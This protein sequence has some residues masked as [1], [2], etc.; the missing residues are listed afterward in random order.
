M[1]S[2]FKFLDSYT[3]DD[4]E[5]FFGR[6]REIEELYHRVFESK[7]MLVYGVSGT[8]KSSLIYCG[9]ANKFQETDWLPLNIRRGSNIIESFAS[10]IKSSS[11][12]PQTGEISTPGQFKKAVRSLYLDHYKPVFF[13][14][15]QF[16][17]LFIFGNKDEKRSF[18][19][20]IKSLVDSDIQCR[21]IFVM[22]E[23]YMANITEFEKFIPTIFSNRVRIEKMSHLNAIAAIKGPC[24][25]AGISLE[26]G[27]AE[28]LLEK[29]SPGSTDVE[30][31]Y[32]Q[33]FLDR[34]LRLTS[35]NSPLSSGTETL[36]RVSMGV[37]GEVS[38]TTR[39]ILQG[40]IGGG[41]FFTTSLLTHAGNVS[42]ILGNFL[43]DQIALME[44]PDDAM[45]VL[46]A[47]IS[48][49]GTKRPASESE[50]I[51]NVRSLGKD[52]PAERV[53]EQIQL[54]VNL[55]LLRDKD[56]KGRYELRHDALASKIFEKFTLSEKELLEVRKYIENAFYSYETRGI[57]LNKQDL[58]YLA[59]Y[60][61]KL[62]LPQN[63][64]DYVNQSRFK[65][66]SQRKALIRMTRIS[67][68]IFVL[69]IAAI[70]RS[71]LGT[72]KNSVLNNQ[73][74]SALFQSKVNPGKGLFTALNIWGK[75]SSSPVLQ[76]I[77]LKDFQKIISSKPDS[78]NPFFPISKDLEPVKL[79]SPVIKAEISKKGTFI[80][81]CMENNKAFILN[82]VTNR[83][84]I[85]KTDG[86]LIHIEI[87]EKDSLIALVYNNNK[88]VVCDFNGN[89]RYTFE[90]TCNKIM[91]ERLVRFFPSGDYQLVTTKNN[92]ALI[93]DK[94]GKIVFELK[95]HSGKVNS[96]DVSP[97][98]RFVATASADKRVFLW[99]YNHISKQL[100][101]YDSLIGHY[102]T[103]WSCQFNRT[104]KYVITAS[105][106]STI[107]IWNLKGKE[108]NPEFRFAREF[109]GDPRSKYNKKE[110]DPDAANPSFSAYY[111]KFCNASFSSDEKEIVA[112]GYSFNSDSSDKKVPFYNKVLYF[113]YY[114]SFFKWHNYSFIDL[115]INHIGT[116][117]PE[118]F[119]QLV[120]SDIGNM[121][122][123]ANEKSGKIY[124]VDA[125]GLIFL[126]LNG[127]NP[128]FSDNGNEILW[129]NKNEIN[130][131]P[132]T[133]EKINR[134]LKRNNISS[135]LK[136]IEDIFVEL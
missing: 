100:S 57:M 42:D 32:L 126:T 9:L 25:I 119:N 85:L 30:L 68:L 48:G 8:G 21:F 3:K 1:R 81:G 106:D 37:Q 27:F 135:S 82:T 87:S 33:V 136:G 97:D 84:H 44:N 101:L 104:G 67:A 79:E 65:L 75:D 115:S 10:A 26:E 103:I 61:R 86:D 62:I 94:T 71:Y 59:A 92:T 29:L 121:A 114:S 93:Y 105:A 110:Y 116:F 28:A 112:T 20:I 24:K 118:S 74:G 55:R 122:A 19:Q 76:Y 91:N 50:T 124:L 83:L 69:I 11:I 13:I 47:F 64:T 89:A 80:F 45:T 108:I 127:T 70:G 130:K 88:G 31:T 134:I 6:E 131:I 46:K 34:I 36:A 41:C 15:D 117:V 102:D 107:K 56:D 73:I 40:E 120:I 72:Q 23:E 132:V 38:S 95:G 129:T 109:N 113:D 2:P 125:G 43:D 4:R 90:A 49:K 35:S 16:E 128:M 39:E 77:I 133:P 96:V 58:E 51:D 54:F 14:L 60:E 78:A 5:I 111:R 18:I 17:E 22:R 7:I 12:T 63:L 98:G 123:A 66:L 53:K 52:V 99:N